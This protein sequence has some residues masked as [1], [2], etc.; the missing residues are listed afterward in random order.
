MF[1][2]KKNVDYSK[3]A[4]K[5]SVDEKPSKMVKDRRNQEK[6]GKKNSQ[7]KWEAEKNNRLF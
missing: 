1:D 3:A 4:R 7:V 2:G 6:E 5:Y